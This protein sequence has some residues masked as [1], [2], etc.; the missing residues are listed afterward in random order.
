MSHRVFVAAA[1]SLVMPLAALADELP[2]R[3]AGLWELRMSPNGPMPA[4]TM[5]QCT[6]E[7]TDRQMSTA[8]SPVA[9][10][11]C[12]KNTVTKTSSGYTTESTCTVAGKTAITRADITGDFESAYTVRVASQSGPGARETNATIDAQWVGACKA[13]QKAGDV[14]MPGGMKVNV[15]D[16]A[17]QRGK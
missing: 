8:I 9:N 7:T 14:I 6:D 13:D 11:S 5:Q 12:S 15:K 10:E 3:R 2:I 4:V 16:L 1:L 17:A